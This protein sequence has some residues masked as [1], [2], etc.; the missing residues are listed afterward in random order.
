MLGEEESG[1]SRRISTSDDED[2]L[3]SASLCFRLRGGVVD[4]DAF[5][6]SEPIQCETS[7]ARSR[8]DDDRFGAH[9]LAIVDV[10]VVTIAVRPQGSRTSVKFDPNAELSCLQ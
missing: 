5:K 9:D 8:G 7:I 2:R 3:T 4:A 1:L 10:D 6:I